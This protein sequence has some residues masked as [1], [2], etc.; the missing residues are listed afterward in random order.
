MKKNTRINSKKVEGN[1]KNNNKKD[2]KFMY[3]RQEKLKV[4]S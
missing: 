3:E 2:R 4:G 1:Y